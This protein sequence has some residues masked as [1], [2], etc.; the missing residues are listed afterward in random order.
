MCHL[1]S[2][3]LKRKNVLPF[4][5][6]KNHQTIILTNLSIKVVIFLKLTWKYVQNNELGVREREL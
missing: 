4:G 3:K 5:N 6:V 1:Y 2:K